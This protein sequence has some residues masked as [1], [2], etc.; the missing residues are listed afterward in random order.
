M[1]FRWK[2]ITL[3]FAIILIVLIGLMSQLI[4]IVTQL[5]IYDVDSTYLPE[6][7]GKSQQI[8]SL[9]EIQALVNGI[10]LSKKAQFNKANLVYGGPTLES[11][12]IANLINLKGKL[13]FVF[14]SNN[15]ES[16]FGFFLEKG[17]DFN[18]QEKGV[19]EIV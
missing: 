18:L 4:R 19:V 6:L 2:L 17:F 10:A 15:G 12:K 13:V 3:F 11:D 16:K 1:I 14:H 9:P 5:K 8:N 7:L